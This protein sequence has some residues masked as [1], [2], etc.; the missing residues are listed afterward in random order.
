MEDC[1]PTTHAITTTVTAA[2]T[3][4][5]LTAL[6]SATTAGMESLVKS[7]LVQENHA[8]LTHNALMEVFATGIHSIKP[9][10]FLL[11]CQNSDTM[12]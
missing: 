2:T 11:L 3:V 7:D 4:N 10:L 6:A 9:L 12:T 8:V 1:G 5:V